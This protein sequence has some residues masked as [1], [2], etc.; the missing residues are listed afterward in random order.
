MMKSRL[1]MLLENKRENILKSHLNKINES[2]YKVLNFLILI[3]AGF[4]N[5]LGSGLFLSCAK[6]LDGGISGTAM[7][8]NYLV[9]FNAP[10]YSSVFSLTFFLVV[11]NI[12]FFIVGVKKIGWQM[13]IYSF[14]AIFSYSIAVMIYT[15]NNGS[16]YTPLT[17]VG[18]FADLN[19]PEYSLVCA[20]F[21]GL[22]SGIGSGLTVKFGGAMDGVD[23]LSVMVHKKLNMTV[24]Q[25]CM[26]YNAILF[27]LFASVND[28]TDPSINN[29]IG[30]LLSLLSYYINLK[31]IDFINEGLSKS[32]MCI[33]ITEKYGE[34]SD[35]INSKL[36]RSVTFIKSKGYFTGKD[37]EMI[38]SVVNRF[39]VNRLRILISEIDPDAFVTF[40]EVSELVGRKVYFKRRKRDK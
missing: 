24:G 27:V 4:I 37:N 28:Y 26:C 15:G 25:V 6:L 14:V 31:A 1:K 16:W 38:Y 2:K 34:V 9:S 11:L 21:G 40:T 8:L 29:L 5:G 23:V 36:G 30:C 7:L 18:P 12:P 10:S 39:E 17:E 3:V 22:F 32:I 33:I 35:A 20:I 19:K 13:L